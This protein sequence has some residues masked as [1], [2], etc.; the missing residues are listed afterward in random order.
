MRVKEMVMGE[1]MGPGE[2]DPWLLYPSQPPLRRIKKLK[3]VP[4]TQTA[5]VFLLLLP[6][7]RTNQ[8]VPE[9]RGQE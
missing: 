4:S 7:R 9:S 3:T 2:R 8:V 6:S 1:K 5:S